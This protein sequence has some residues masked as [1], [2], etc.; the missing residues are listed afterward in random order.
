MERLVHNKINKF[1]LEQWDPIG[2]HDI[3]EAQDEYSSYVYEI[4]NIILHSKS[5]EV[6]FEYLWELETH[7]MGL[8]GNRKKTHEFAQILF[9][10]IQEFMKNSK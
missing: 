4:Y 9:N 10:E 7:H 2:I 6:L 3:D 1:L 8:K 5:Y